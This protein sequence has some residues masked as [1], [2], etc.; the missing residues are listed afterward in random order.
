M[1]ILIP[2]KS[3]QPVK[4]ER[5]LNSLVRKAWHRHKCCQG[6]AVRRDADDRNW[7]YTQHD[8]LPMRIPR[9]KYANGRVWHG[10]IEWLFG[11]LYPPHI[12]LAPCYDPHR[13]CRLARHGLRGSFHAGLQASEMLT[14]GRSAKIARIPS[15]P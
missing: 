4:S 5:V 13:A 1:K 14:K 9:A 3:I 11:G 15:C 2:P 8:I 7:L 6:L 12:F 10:A